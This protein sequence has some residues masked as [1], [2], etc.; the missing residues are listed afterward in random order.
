MKQILLYFD[1]N[2]VIDVMKRRNLELVNAVKQSQFLGAKVVYSPA[3]IEEVANI[4]R[5]EASDEDCDRY[6]RGHLDFLAG[7]TDCWEILPPKSDSDGPCIL[8]QEHPCV[9]ETCY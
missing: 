6:I 4:Y 3:H 1:H 2:T 9:F 7:L 8:K 5:T